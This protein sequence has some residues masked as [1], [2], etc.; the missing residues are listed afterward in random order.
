MFIWQRNK[1][2]GMNFDIIIKIRGKNLRDD[3]YTY[4]EMGNQQPSTL[5]N[6]ECAVHRLDGYR[7]INFA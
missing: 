1:N 6:L 7:R 3:G 4:P 2:F 5:Y